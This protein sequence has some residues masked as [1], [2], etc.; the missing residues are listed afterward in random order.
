M[1]G[2]RNG[3]PGLWHR[4]VESLSGFAGMTWDATEVELILSKT[5]PQPSYQTIGT[6]PQ[7]H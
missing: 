6:W 7:C 3:R 2:R 1:P 5:G 4:Q